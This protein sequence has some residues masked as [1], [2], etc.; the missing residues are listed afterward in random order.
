M[1][2]IFI[3][4]PRLFAFDLDGTLLNSRKDLSEATL[5]A[6]SEMS[7]MGLHIVFASG[8]IKSSMEQYIQRCN[9]PVSTVSLNGAAVYANVRHNGTPRIYDASLPAEYADFLINYAALNSIAMNYYHNETLYAINNPKNAP[10]LDLYFNQTHSTYNFTSS[11]HNFL[12]CSPSKILF[13]GSPE[14]L[15]EQEAYFT[16]LWGTSVYICRTWDYYLE[17][18]NPSANKG[19][20]LKALADFYQVSMD[21]TVSFGDALNDIPMFEVAG[22]SVA[23]SNS[24]DAVKNAATRVSAWSNDQN[25]IAEEWKYFR[26]MLI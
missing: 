20:G 23:V 8:R 25:A 18:M 21:E 4:K 6:L 2:P 9:F 16:R 17:F 19:F 26:Q 5:V 13:L 1:S 10:W 11:L 7:S 22:I 14:V 12:G 3:T 15:D 24:S